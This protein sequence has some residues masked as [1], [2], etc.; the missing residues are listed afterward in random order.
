[1]PHLRIG[2]YKEG[3]TIV[4]IQ[5]P[6]YPM[7]GAELDAPSAHKLLILYRRTDFKCEHVIIANCDFSL[8]TQLLERN[9]YITHSVNQYV[10]QA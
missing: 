4:Q 10:A 1:M 2:P 8:S 6:F 3:V 7:Y 9:V 5:M